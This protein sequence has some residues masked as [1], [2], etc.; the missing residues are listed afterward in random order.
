MKLSEYGFFTGD[1]KQL[2]PAKHVMPYHVQI[3]L[4]SPLPKPYDQ[5]TTLWVKGDMIN[6]VGF[7]RLDLLRF[8][9]N[10]KGTR[11]YYLS[12]LD[13][14]QLK[15]VYSCILRGMGLSNLTKSL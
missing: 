7:H 11:T 9:K 14:N 12:T 2:I 13:E 3:T 1:M 5:S 15:D 10:R 4:K 6:T 8:E